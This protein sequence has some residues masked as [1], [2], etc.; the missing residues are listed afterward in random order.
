MR[1]RTFLLAL[2]LPLLLAVPLLM[3]QAKTCSD[4]KTLGWDQMTCC[5]PGQ[6]VGP[7]GCTGKPTSCPEGLVPTGDGCNPLNSAAAARNDYNPALLDPSLAN[8][9]APD[10]FSVRLETTQGNIIIDVTRDW[11]PI[12]ADRFYNLVTIGY[13]DSASFF[14]VIAG[15]M[16]QFGLHGDPKVNAVWRVAEIQDDPA[17]LQSNLPGY[18]SFAM[19]GPNSRTTQLFMSLGDNHRLDRM[20]FAPF[21][22]LREMTVLEKLY[23]GYGE[24]APSG[25]GPDQ[26]RIQDEGRAYLKSQFPELDSIIKATVLSPEEAAAGRAP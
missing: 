22:K 7:F 16:A 6:N 23:D 13:Y 15:F 26:R 12:G 3:G 10:T 8:K 4:G 24:G 14:R 11:A 25:R 17:G 1:T 18:V 21:G 19:A 2:A 20:G 5:W 9:T